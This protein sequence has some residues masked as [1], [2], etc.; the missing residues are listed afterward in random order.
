[1]IRER[2]RR[3]VPATLLLHASTSLCALAGAMPLASSIPAGGIVDS[4]VVGRLYTWVRLYDTGGSHP[5]R[6]GAL[7]LLVALL[8]TPFLRV[9]WLSAL[10][11][12]AP[13]HEHA[14]SAS[15]RYPQAL[16]V[17]AV[18]A[19]YGLGLCGIAWLIAQGTSLALGFSH[20][21]RLQQ[22]SGGLLALPFVL[23]ALIHAPCVS[24]LA[25]VQL[26][27]G[28]PGARSALTVALAG[29]DR[30][31]CLVRARCELAILLF[32]GLAFSLRL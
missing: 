9:V 4:P 13:L 7:P 27:R 20:D 1:M 30:R 11:G 24:D 29:I 2:L 19:G 32:F 21:V 3:A 12:E 5:V 26:A 16:A 22:C 6:Y 28:T 25:H 17:W 18:C 31:A 23:A 14:R 10:S 8:L 15:R